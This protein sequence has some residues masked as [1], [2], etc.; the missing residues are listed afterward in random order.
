MKTI[1]QLF[2][3]AIA[4]IL[5]SSC[6][7]SIYPVKSLNN[8]YAVE[9]RNAKEIEIRDNMVI[10]LSEKELANADYEIIS[11]NA[12]KPATFLPIKKLFIKKMN[13]KFFEAAA[14]KAHE[15]GGNAVLITAPGFYNVLNVTNWNGQKPAQSFQNPIYDTEAMDVLKNGHLREAKRSVRTRAEKALIEEIEENLSYASNFDEVNFIRTKIQALSD[16]NLEKPNK[17][18]TKAVNKYSK[19]CNALDKKIQRAID[20]AAKAKK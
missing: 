11:L 1:K 19:K 9:M 5:L 17:N 3:V 4:A 12:F 16:Y 15:Q 6:A 18:I 10:L 8:G 13:R 7:H 20:K 2:V 14:K